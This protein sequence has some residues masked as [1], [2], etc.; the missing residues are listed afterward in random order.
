MYSSSRDNS[1]QHMLLPTAVAINQ[2][3]PSQSIYLFRWRQL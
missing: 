3:W 2:L 1:V